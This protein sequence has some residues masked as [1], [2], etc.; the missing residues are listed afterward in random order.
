MTD[1]FVSALRTIFESLEYTQ[2]LAPGSPSALDVAAL[3]K[4][5]LDYNNALLALRYGDGPPRVRENI[6]K[7]F[8]AIK[9]RCDE[10]AKSY[11][12]GIGCGWELRPG[13]RFC[14]CV[15]R[16][17]NLGMVIE[18]DQP[19]PGSLEA[20]K[21]AVREFG[22]RLYLPGEFQGSVRMQ[23]PEMSSEAIYRPSL[24]TE[25][26]IGWVKAGKTRQDP[27]SYRTRNW[28]KRP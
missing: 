14:S 25:Y 2:A 22:G 8:G 3:H 11:D 26:E 7:L 5:E 23:P 24:S 13:E 18:W 16:T 4:K 19:R 21:L 9:T 10:V 1:K 15:L 12:F 27:R 6:E 28:L 20:A 17:A